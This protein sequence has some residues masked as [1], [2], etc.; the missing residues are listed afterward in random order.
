MGQ[1]WRVVARC[2]KLCLWPASPVG[3]LPVTL[4]RQRHDAL[5]PVRRDLAYPRRVRS[6]HRHLPPPLQPSPPSAPPVLGSRTDMPANHDSSNNSK[7]KWSA[8]PPK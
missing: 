8:P 7:W 6:P 3:R 2:S 1:V 4:G 5:R